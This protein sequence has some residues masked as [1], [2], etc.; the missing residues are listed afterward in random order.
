MRCRG[1]NERRGRGRLRRRGGA[2]RDRE[3]QQL[4]VQR[5]WICHGA[6]PGRRAAA[7]V[8]SPAP[9][10]PQ[11]KQPC[12]QAWQ[13]ASGD[14]RA[15][16]RAGYQHVIGV[17]RRPHNSSAYPCRAGGHARMHGHAS[18]TGACGACRGTPAAQARVAH[19]W[20]RQQHSAG[21]DVHTHP[22]RIIAETVAA[23][24]EE[25]SE[26]VLGKPNAE[27]C[28]WIADPQRW[29]GAIELSILARWG[30]TPVG[31]ALQHCSSLMPCSGTWALLVRGKQLRTP[32]AWCPFGCTIMLRCGPLVSA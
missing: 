27:Y 2:A 12:E 11:G 30:Q 7:Q 17:A 8:G 14:S 25:Y 31:A 4:P 5:G 1:G 13:Q 26:A 22:R 10:R 21:D 16:E 24:P 23:D 9:P 3:R 28:R 32:A 6:Q 19:A 18:S 15:G 29:G 20:A